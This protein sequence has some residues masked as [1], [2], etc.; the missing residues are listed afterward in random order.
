MKKIVYIL[1]IAIVLV[2]CKK[3]IK[4]SY[5]IEGTAKEVYNGMRVYLSKIDERGRPIAMDTAIVMNETFSFNGSLKNPE[6]HYLTINGT[7]GKLSIMLENNDLKLDIDNK[8]ITNSKFEGSESHD[9]FQTYN[10]KISELQQN[11]KNA[12][13]NLRD[14]KFLKDSLKLSKDQIKYQEANK[15]LADFPYDYIEDNNNNF[16]ILPVFESLL[17]SRGAELDKLIKIYDSFNNEIKSAP[18]SAKIK[19]NIDILKANVE[20]EKS[21]AIGATAPSFSAPNPEGEMI[22][23]NDVVKKGKVTIIDFWAAWC[24]PCRR[25]NPN[26]VKVYNEYHDKGLEIIGVGLDGRRGQQKPKDAWIKAIKDDML[27]WHQV[28]NLK[29]FD[30]IA[31]AYNVNSIPSMFVLDNN[32]KIIAKNL[33]GRALEN[34]IAQLLN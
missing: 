28:S 26:V 23:L 34:K 6:L 18:A 5:T 20:L 9:V 7:P 25:E 3:E 17:Y 22:A 16:G 1:V 21:T 12:R 31:K 29:Y 27:E 4:N 2:G 15:K 24:G 13:V 10:K 14:S 11:V 32:G 8:I 30:E 19:K 33:R